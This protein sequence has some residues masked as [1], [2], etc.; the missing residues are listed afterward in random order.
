MTST[1]LPT[2][3]ITGS[4]GYLGS[5]PVER[6]AADHGIMSPNRS[7]PEE[8]LTEHVESIQTY[9]SW[10]GSV[11]NELEHVVKRS[12]DPSPRLC[13]WQPASTS[14]ASPARSSAGLDRMARGG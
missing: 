1:Y 13:T 9:L 11:S 4:I 3:M 7:E 10:V 14:R 5:A 2:I 8:P 12:P 6:L